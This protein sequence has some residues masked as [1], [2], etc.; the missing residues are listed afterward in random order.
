[1]PRL[2]E[3]AACDP[4]LPWRCDVGLR[5][6]ARG[7]CA[8]IQAQPLGAPCDLS[9]AQTCEGGG[10]C[11]LS[12]YQNIPDVCAP[13]SPLG[14]PCQYDVQCPWDASCAP[15]ARRC[16]ARAAFDSPCP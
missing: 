13:A 16:V 5:C 7:V 8:P 10:A 6:V 1:M 15:T 4:T 14:G 9:A 12:Q 11:W 3:G 2:I